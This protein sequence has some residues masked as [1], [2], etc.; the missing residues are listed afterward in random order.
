LNKVLIGINDQT[1]E[2]NGLLHSSRLEL[3]FYAKRQRV[4][5]IAKGHGLGVP[6]DQRKRDVSGYECDLNNSNVWSL[7]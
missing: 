3:S 6:A 5:T 1:G 7:S 2:P 4:G